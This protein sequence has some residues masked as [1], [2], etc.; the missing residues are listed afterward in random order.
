MVEDQC[1]YVKQMVFDMKLNDCNI[2][3]EKIE[4]SEIQL[5]ILL[6][7]VCRN[8]LV[9]INR[10][11]K[12]LNIKGKQI[13]TLMVISKH[14]G[15]TQDSIVKLFQIDK[16]FIARIVRELEDDKLLYRTIDPE[17]RRKYNIFLT[18]KGENIIP[19]IK[20]IEEEW[21]KI[22]CDGLN[23]D[24]NLKLVKFMSLLA[25]NSVDKIKNQ[26]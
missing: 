4:N 14:P 17:N 13:P 16:G 23:K 25:Q 3:D 5:E 21:N 2:Q 11:A 9:F 7:I 19:K 1:R 20:D 22:V 8:H 10:E 18:E 6:S 15:I 26:S 24:E 12:A